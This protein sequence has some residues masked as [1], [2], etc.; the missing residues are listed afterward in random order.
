MQDTSINRENYNNDQDLKGSNASE[1]FI[2]GILFCI[3]F[4]NILDAMMVMPLGPDFALALHLP[5]HLLGFIGGSYTASACLS[6]LFLGKFF[7]R[8]DRKKMMQTV[9]VGL[10]CAT[11]LGALAQNYWQLIFT[12]IL[13]GA[14][15][16]PAAALTLTIVSDVVPASRRGKAMGTI[17][18][19]FSLASILGVPLGLELARIRDWRFPFICVGLICATV[20]L[21]ASWKLPHFLPKKGQQKSE[22]YWFLEKNVLIALFI[23]GIATISVMLIVPN[24]SAYLQNNL[25]WPREKLGLLYLIGGSITIFSNP[26]SGRW[27]DRQGVAP[28]IITSTLFFIIIL[29]FGFINH[30]RWFPVWPI[31]PG[32]MLATTMRFVC[33]STLNSKVPRPEERG[34]FMGLQNS[35]QQAM[36]ACGAFLPTIF[37]S[38]NNLGHLTGIHHVA[39]LSAAIGLC[40]PIAAIILQKKMLKDL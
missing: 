6:S 20:Y 26:L 29:Y 14:F 31:L 9:L 28:A 39:I 10:T 24:M 12:R 5:N 19:G 11:C 40:V 34:R 38:T 27:I 2:V 23:N 13:A 22:K 18:S 35:W 37:L 30:P 36:S 7:D 3:Q 33:I 16:G 32:F 21:F 17:M 4:V 25:A 1:K 15:G 8:I